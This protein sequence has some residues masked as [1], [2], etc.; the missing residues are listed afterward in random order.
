M[1]FFL[2]QSAL[3]D[4]ERDDVCPAKWHG[5]WMT[6]EI[7]TA[8]TEPMNNGNYGEYLCLG[9]GAPGRTTITDLPRLRGG[10]KSVV[11][12]RIEE[13]AEKFKQLFIDEKH[14]DWLGFHIGG[15]QIPL[16]DDKDQGTLDFD[17]INL[18]EGDTWIF[19][20]KFTG[21]MPR[22]WG[23]LYSKDF[24]QLVH[25]RDLYQHNFGIVPRVGII[26]LDYSP[27]KELKFIELEIS[28]QKVD[29][30]NLRFDAAWAAIKEY[31]EKGWTR[32]PSPGECESCPLVCDK[33]IVQGQIVYEKIPY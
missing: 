10:D 13:Q 3:K 12:L 23:D 5:T 31:G 7:T 4:L 30:K 32:S 25:Y 21:S 1:E 26:V 19:D 16:K 9:G 28:K 33:R 17:A 11:Q 15:K 24:I 14:P 2:S 27:R 8:T 20:L 29:E 6:G 18:V 22:I